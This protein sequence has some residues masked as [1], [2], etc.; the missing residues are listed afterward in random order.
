M[1]QGSLPTVH[2]TE[3]SDSILYQYIIYIAMAQNRKTN[4]NNL[5]TYTNILY[6]LQLIQLENERILLRPGIFKFPFSSVHKSTQYSIL[7]N[8]NLPKKYFA[9][10]SHQVLNADLQKYCILDQLQP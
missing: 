10:Q 6:L 2:I 5:V 4:C 7:Y 8:T 3:S 1:L 9:P